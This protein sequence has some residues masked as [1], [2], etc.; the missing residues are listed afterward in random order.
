M[1]DATP[2]TTVRHSPKPDFA[3]APEST[4][5]PPQLTKFS[6][7]IILFGLL[8]AAVAEKIL[9][10]PFWAF[11]GIRLLPSF[12]LFHG[13]K[14]YPG[15]HTG[16][17]QSALYGPVTGLT[18]AIT[19]LMRTPNAA[20][21]LGSALTVL[22]CFGAAF[23]MHMAAASGQWRRAMLPFL[24][25]GFMILYLEPLRY[26]CIRIH[27]D[28]PGIFFGA[29][30]IIALCDEK[31]PRMWA[32][33]ASAV[34]AVL[35]VWA[36]QPFV[37]LPVGLCIFLAVTEG[38]Q[39]LVRYFLLLLL[40]T[41]VISGVFAA[42]YGAHGLYFNLFWIPGHQA[43][44]N[45]AHL[46]ALFQSSRWLLTLGF[47]VFAGLTA[48]LIYLAGLGE[49]SF[50]SRR[51]AGRR[52]IWCASLF[53]GVCL[54]PFSLMGVSKQGGDVNSFSFCLFFL[55]L[56]FML[57]LQEGIIVSEHSTGRMAK[58]ATVGV[59]AIAMVFTVPFIAQ[60][61]GM[62][63]AL[64]NSN[65]EVAYRYVLAHPG[66]V[67]FPW[68]PLVH[69]MAEGGD[70]NS[71]YGLWDHIAAGVG[72]TEQEFRAHIPAA[73]RAVAFGRDGSQVNDIDLMTFLPEFNCAW[74]DSKLRGFVVL[75]KTPPATG[76]QPQLNSDVIHRR[77]GA[78]SAMTTQSA[79]ATNPQP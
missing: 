31:R 69:L 79:G 51:T 73:A 66:Q 74:R 20:V 48:C 68:F 58:A 14:V 36:K 57:L 7:L 41:A 12:Y 27:A 77:R 6:T 67:Y 43:W 54:I 46:M 1:I 61:P 65:Q 8:A 59:M 52:K 21:L 30:A 55:L 40:A 76:C 19:G 64:P 28:A 75:S 62:I 33:I 32:L 50:A 49:L 39:R 29:L 70:Y 23:W 10:T 22:L 53:A 17:L 24:A 71:A 13:I 60:I 3:H 47:T 37:G 4:N 5:L 9:E 35:S 34:C 78:N 38:A 26:S 63:K 45:A 18:Y 25:T 11:N 44:K 42:I 2:A 72:P 56:A 16:S 15:P